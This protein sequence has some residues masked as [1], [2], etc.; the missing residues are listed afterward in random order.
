MFEL[1]NNIALVTGAS[2]GI[3]RGIAETLARSGAHVICISRNAEAVRAVADQLV[4][5]NFSASS[6][7]CDISSADSVTVLIKKIIDEFGQI[8]ILV[9]NA[10]VTRDTLLMRMSETDWDTVLNT[11]LKGAFNTI[12]AVARPMMKQRR[13]R[14]INI[15][16]VVGIT[17]NA[18]Q[19]NYS[20]SKAGL[21]G[22]T[23][24][25]ARE[26]ASRG[27]TV[28]CVAP[29]Y[30]D[31]DMTSGL[32]DDLKIELIK[33]IPL[34]KIGNTDDVATIVLFLASDA[35]GYITGQTY[36]VDGGMTMS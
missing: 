7:A 29:G 32:K 20:A 26:L 19:A 11:N 3:G 10:G 9:N 24:A 8:D 14:I 35:A 5:N 33:Q 6:A 23:K 17:G 16:S 13:G 30:I 1:H 22:L 31:T 4:N 2:R 28:N 18:G 36:A 12:K 15:A 25:T 21:I 27:I 34:G